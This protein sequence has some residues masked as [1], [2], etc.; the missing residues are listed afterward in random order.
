[1]SHSDDVIVFTEEEEKEKEKGVSH[2]D[3]FIVIT[4]KEEEESR[5]DKE[6]HRGDSRPYRGFWPAQ[7]RS[8]VL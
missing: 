3:D 1:M 8:T 2:S 6:I 7:V 5:R 4:E